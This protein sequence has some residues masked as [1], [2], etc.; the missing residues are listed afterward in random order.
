MRPSRIIHEFSPGCKASACAD[1]IE[2]AFRVVAFRDERDEDLARL[3]DVD[4]DPMLVEDA[5]AVARLPHRES[6]RASHP[7]SASNLREL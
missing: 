3:G 4:A 6:T 5:R 7:T 1:T 2:R